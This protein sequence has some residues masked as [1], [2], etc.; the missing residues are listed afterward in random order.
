MSPL[1]FTLFFVALLVGYVLVHIRMA[2]FEEHLK[3]LAGIRSLDERLRSIEEKVGALGQS[4]ERD[5]LIRV[6]RQLDQLHEDL[7]DLREATERVGEATV[8]LPAMAARAEGAAD[9]SGP[10]QPAATRIVAIIETR[11]L[12]LGYRDLRLLGDLKGVDFTDEVEVQVEAMRSGMP[13]KGRVVV[14]NGSVS[15]V[16]LQTAAQAFP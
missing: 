11:L 5:G 9:Y 6:T 8:S 14:R 15:D 1:Q 2:R 16:A 10:N 13:C 3:E 4:A 12:Q 7:E